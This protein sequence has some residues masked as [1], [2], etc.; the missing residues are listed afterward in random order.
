[1]SE[2]HCRSGRQSGAEGP[3][4]VEAG[5][6]GWA[7]RLPGASGAGRTVGAVVSEVGYCPTTDDT[8]VASLGALH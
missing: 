2:R 7:P 3:L 6:S 8:L 1:L 4:W 5:G